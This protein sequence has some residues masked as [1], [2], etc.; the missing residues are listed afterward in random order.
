VRKIIAISIA[1]WLSGCASNSGVVPMSANSFSVSRQAATGFEGTARIKSQA[2]V[3]ARN[4]CSSQNKPANILSVLEQPPAPFGGFPKV[5]VEFNC[6]DQTK[7]NQIADDQHCKSYG[8]AVGS[9]AYVQCR[10][11]QEIARA[12]RTREASAREA[13]NTA[14]SEADARA[15]RGLAAASMMQN[16]RPPP[17]IRVENCNPGG[18]KPNTCSY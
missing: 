15:Y 6:E 16:N 10:N 13:A 14:A 11:N 1:V 3:D 17:V 9:P 12:E 8:A 4:Y 5:D 18:L 7:I 2:L